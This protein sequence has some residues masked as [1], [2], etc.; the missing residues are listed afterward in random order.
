[1]KKKKDGIIAPR[2]LINQYMEMYSKNGKNIADELLHGYI[3]YLETGEKPKEDE[4]IYWLLQ[5]YQDIPQ[6]F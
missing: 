1:M 4:A 6:S 3:E 5:P 2:S